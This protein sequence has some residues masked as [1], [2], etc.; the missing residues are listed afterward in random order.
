MLGTKIGNET[1]LAVLIHQM[2]PE[3][4]PSLDL[5]NPHS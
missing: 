5:N 1:T 3:A 4:T 2:Y